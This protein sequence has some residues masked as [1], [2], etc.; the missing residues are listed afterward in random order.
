MTVTFS[1]GTGT[2]TYHVETV[3]LLDR[4]KVSLTH[5]YI[6]SHTRT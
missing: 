5:T 2:R 3:D 1:K 4:L 6:H